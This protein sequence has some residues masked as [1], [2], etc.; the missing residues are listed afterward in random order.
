[1]LLTELLTITVAKLL[2]L[3]LLLQGEAKTVAAFRQDPYGCG[4]G[5]SA[6]RATRD[7]FSHGGMSRE[8]C[9]ALGDLLDYCGPGGWVGCVGSTP[10]RKAS[11][12]SHLFQ[13]TP[14]RHTGGSAG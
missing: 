13:L 10:V 11:Q 3:L 4:E 9:P 12:G 1:M 8:R 2:A 7:P 5:L 6:K 14:Y